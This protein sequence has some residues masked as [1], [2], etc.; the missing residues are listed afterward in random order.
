MEP[1]ARAVRIQ[2][3][4]GLRERVST[5]AR[6]AGLVPSSS[7]PLTLV[8]ITGQHL[9][10]SLDQLMVDSAPHLVVRLL[11][12]EVVVGPFVAPGVGACA[13]C[14][15]VS[16]AEGDHAVEAL[17]RAFGAPDPGEA[18]AYAGPDAPW[19]LLA[20]AV[21]LAARDLVAYGQGLVPP[22]WSSTWTLRGTEPPRVRQW[23]RHAW[24][25]CSWFD[26]PAAQ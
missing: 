16:T 8:V 23:H 9:P 20:L 3:P 4:P 26:L 18:Q 17:A 10:E 11:P 15:A 13:R 5:V 21:S 19:H 25:G 24:C 1:A 6:A 14:V 12:D 22:T 2:T 7:A